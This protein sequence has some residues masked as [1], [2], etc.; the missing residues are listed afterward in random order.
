MGGGES[1]EQGMMAE[2]SAAP[3]TRVT[4]VCELPQEDA[5]ELNSGPLLEPSPLGAANH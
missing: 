5:G 2:A 4:G 3:Q 1:T